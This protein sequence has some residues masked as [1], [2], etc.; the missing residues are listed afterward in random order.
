MMDATHLNTRFLP[1]AEPQTPPRRRPA[2]E[3]TG[4]FDSSF[5]D[6]TMLPGQ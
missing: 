3:S 2:Y 1:L 6:L 4:S 5:D